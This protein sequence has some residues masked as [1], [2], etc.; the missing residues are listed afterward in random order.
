MIIIFQVLNSNIFLILK[1][2]DRVLA[3]GKAQRWAKKQQELNEG[4]I[5]PLTQYLQDLEKQVKEKK[6]S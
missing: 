6:S 3:E 2:L 5:G 1:M 4:K